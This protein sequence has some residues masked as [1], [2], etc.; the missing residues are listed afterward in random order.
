MVLALWLFCTTKWVCMQLNVVYSHESAILGLWRILGPFSSRNLGNRWKK[1]EKPSRR[2]LEWKCSKYSS[3][4]KKRK[5]VGLTIRPDLL[6]KAREMNL[7]LSKTLE[8]SLIQLI[9]SQNGCFLN[10]CSF[11]KKIQWCSGRD[12][13]PGLR[14]ERPKYLTWLYS[15]EKK[16][17]LFFYRSFPEHQPK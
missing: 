6:E 13:N 16:K 15:A 1:S 3:E 11:P 4:S 10:E 9:E 7:N 2:L 12:S 8:K 5:T 17:N 14:L